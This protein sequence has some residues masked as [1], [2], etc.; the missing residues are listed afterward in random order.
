MMVIYRK[1]ENGENGM[2]I[3]SIQLTDKLDSDILGIEARIELYTK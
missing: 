3:Y 1:D 2:D